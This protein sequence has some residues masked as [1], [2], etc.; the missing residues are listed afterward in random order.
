MLQNQT[1]VAQELP[2][3]PALRSC[4][5]RIAVRCSIDCCGIDAMSPT[6]VLVGLW[7][8]S[9]GAKKTTQALAQARVVLSFAS[10]TTDTLS[11]EFLHYREHSEND[12]ARLKAF[13]QSLA[14]A[15]EACT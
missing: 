2:I 9:V 12:R 1:H 15:L 5:T 13:F 10:Q 6:P 4:L 3:G 7:A 14:A 8:D 11:S